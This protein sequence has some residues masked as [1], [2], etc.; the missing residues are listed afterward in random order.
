MGVAATLGREEAP[1]A[2][3]LVQV[4][5]LGADGRQPV[6]LGLLGGDG[7]FDDKAPKV[8]EQPTRALRLVDIE[9]GAQ[10]EDFGEGERVGEPR[11]LDDPAKDPMSVSSVVSTRSMVA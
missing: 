4:I 6:L 9:V 3:P 11:E 8:F 10:R 1:G 7:A 2:G 5:Q